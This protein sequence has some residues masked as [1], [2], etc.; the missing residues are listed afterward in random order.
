MASAVSFVY[1]DSILV[2]IAESWV[3]SGILSPKSISKRNDRLLQGH[4]EESCFSSSLLSR[5]NRFFIAL[6]SSPENVNIL[7]FSLILSENG[8]R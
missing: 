7:S 4:E 1:P 8:V 3:F 5:L 2:G 6:I